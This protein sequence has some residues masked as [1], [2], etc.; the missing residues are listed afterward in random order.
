VSLIGKLAS[1]SRVRKASRALALDPSA[2]NYITL[3]REHVIAGSTEEVRKVC[4]EGLQL[5]PGNADLKRL[6]ARA[7]ALQLEERV[8][9]LQEQFKSA[10]RPAVARELCEALIDAG[11]FTRAD[12]IARTWE[13]QGGDVE[14]RYWRARATL[15]RFL[16]ERTAAEG[17]LAY[18]LAEGV[19]EQCPTDSRALE[20]QLE[21][22]RRA[23][24]WQDARRIVARLLELRPGEAELE[25]SFR[26]IMGRVDQARPLAEGLQRVERHGAFVD[27]RQKPAA[28]SVAVRPMLRELTSD[29]EVQAAVYVRGGTALVQG[30]RGATADR[31]ARAVRDILNASRGAARR[32]GIGSPVLIGLEGQQGSLSLAPGEQGTSAVWCSGPLKRRHQDLLSELSGLAGGMNS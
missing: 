9:R 15:E 1:R 16:A 20:L 32:L 18:D 5:H 28:S 10:P 7:H 25:A 31:T 8:R 27:E 30:P 23:G 19:L 2:R 22:V 12:D 14:A 4:D 29:A 17:Q 13:A 24:A 6:A 11:R 21:V 3:A 26:T